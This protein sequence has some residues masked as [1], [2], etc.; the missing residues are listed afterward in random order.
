MPLPGFEVPPGVW[1]PPYLLISSPT[2]SSFPPCSL[3]GC[4]HLLSLGLGSHGFLPQN[5]CFRDHYFPTSCS[6]SRRNAAPIQCLPP[7]LHGSH[8]P[9]P[10]ACCTLSC[11]LLDPFLTLNNI[12]HVFSPSVD[13]PHIGAAPSFR[14]MTL[15]CYFLKS[16]LYE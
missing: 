11:Q 9:F 15:R 10:K 1:I 13:S 8:L 16:L 2:T 4:P 5:S 14:G 3:C 7:P 12:I 6:S